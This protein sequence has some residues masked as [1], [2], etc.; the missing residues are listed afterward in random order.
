MKINPISASVDFESDGVQHGYLK[1]PHS[2]DVSA[3]GAI[4]IP[5]TVI[6]NG[7]GPTALL[8]GG[9]H[10]DEYEGPTA[11]LNLV[12]EIDLSQVTGRIIV[13]PMMNYPAFCART[14]NSPIDQCNMNRIFPGKPDGTVTEKIADYF[15]RTLLPMSDYV[16]DIHSGGKTLNF[17]PF[18]AAHVLD[19]KQQQERC[20]AAMRA[21]SAPCSLMLVELDALGMYDTAAEEMGKV[22]VSTELGGGGST[23]PYTNEIAL[24][25]VK[26][27]LIH[28]KVL[29]GKLV[30]RRSQF[31]E[32]PDDQCY[33]G[34]LH[35]G[36]LEF[37]VEL[38]EA[39]QLG[40]LVARVHDVT[41]N[42]RAPALYHSS[43]EG[44]LLGRHFPGLTKKGDALAVIGVPV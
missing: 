38:G 20:V 32:M 30:E 16:L 10:G 6:K 41:E 9:N 34:G 13:V 40:Q 26:N 1:L 33:I 15:Q 4:M 3:W 29:G 2:D 24:T 5:I 7:E 35:E 17:I 37:M 44:I 27:L 39:V 11:L 19:D 18:A 43:I 22:F 31:M 28:A 14:R 23:T 25:G 8:T 12:R 42:G 21:F 36:L